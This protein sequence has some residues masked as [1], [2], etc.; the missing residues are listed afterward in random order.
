MNGLTNRQA[1][2]LA[3]IRAER[4]AKGYSP[5]LREI[6]TR[7]KIAS[8][9]GV[10]DHLRAL[11]RKGRLRRDLMKSRALIPVEPRTREELESELRSAEARV[12]ALRRQLGAMV[13]GDSTREAC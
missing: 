2:I 8:T 1:E 9:N 4:V 3:F 13:A 5:S 7:F 12:E 11:E 10:N 6:G